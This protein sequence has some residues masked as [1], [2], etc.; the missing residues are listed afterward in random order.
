MTLLH[1]NYFEHKNLEN[2]R[3]DAIYDIKSVELQKSNNKRTIIQSI[4]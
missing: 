2:A 1:L 4:I 3:H